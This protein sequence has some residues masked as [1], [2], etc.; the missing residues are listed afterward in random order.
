M[1]VFMV[2]RDLPGITME[3]LASAQKRAIQVGKQLTA[4]G[5]EVRYIRSM[6]V[7]GE[8]K[9]MCL[10]EAPTPDNVREANERAQIPFTRI[11]APKI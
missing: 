4:E 1:P 9:C 10:F 6:F 8:S 3:E 5:R 2:E 11:V 7:P